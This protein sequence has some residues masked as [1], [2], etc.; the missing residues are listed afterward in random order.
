MK[1]QWDNWFAWVLE[2][3]WRHWLVSQ[4]RGKGARKRHKHLLEKDHERSS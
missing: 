1:T 2:E 4:T 3:L